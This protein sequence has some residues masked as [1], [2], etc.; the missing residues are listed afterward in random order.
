MSFFK[1]Q[2]TLRQR[3]VFLVL[4][5]LLGVIF[6]S[7]SLLQK[8]LTLS[9]KITNIQKL[10]E[11]ASLASSF[12]HEMQKE[13]GMSAGF[14]GSNGTKFT[15]KIRSQRQLT[16]RKQTE[17]TQFLSDFDTSRFN[18]GFNNKLSQGLRHINKL[19]MIRSKVSQL[20]IT[21]PAAL[22]F[23]STSN[24]IFLETIA[25]TAQMSPE[26]S[27]SLIITAYENFL[28]AKERTG[29]ERAVLSN[30]FA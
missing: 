9:S 7:G 26:P 22:G 16:D 25:E 14:I 3:L 13:R 23:Y 17:L 2:G 1:I 6:F 4:V 20:N 28:Q 30:V 24:K 11:Y 15:D 29:I 18:E 10:A 19:S 8:E 27:L 12:V 21:L 5:P